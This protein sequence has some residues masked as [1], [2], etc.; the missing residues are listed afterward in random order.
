MEPLQNLSLN[1]VSHGWFEAFNVNNAI[2]LLLRYPA[3]TPIECVVTTP[4]RRADLEPGQPKLLGEL[5]PQSFGRRLIGFYPAAGRDPK[6]VAAARV[7]DLHEKY[8]AL[9]RQKYCSDRSSLD[10]HAMFPPGE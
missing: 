3:L 10:N 5:S 6:C 8:L 7:T 2:F 1:S 4:E 9:R